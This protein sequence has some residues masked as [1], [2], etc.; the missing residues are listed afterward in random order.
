PAGIPVRSHGDDDR[1]AHR[2]HRRR[3]ERRLDPQ[4]GELARPVQVTSSLAAATTAN[5][6]ATPAPPAPR[7]AAVPAANTTSSRANRARTEIVQRA[8]GERKLPQTTASALGSRTATHQ[9]H[10]CHPH[11]ATPASRP[12]SS[13]KR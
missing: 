9:P 12:S 8:F 6:T 4:G 10:S 1:H 5:A 11:H 13:R 7:Y 3:H 2:R